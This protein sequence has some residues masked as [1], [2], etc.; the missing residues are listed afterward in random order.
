MVRLSHQVLFKTDTFGVLTCGSDRMDF[1]ERLFGFSPDAGNG[2]FEFL[3]FALLTIAVYTIGA[4]RQRRGAT[5][6]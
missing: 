6:R 4:V 5:R 2:V 3:V 1:I